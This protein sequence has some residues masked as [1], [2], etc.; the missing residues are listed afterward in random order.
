ML[1]ASQQALVQLMLTPGLGQGLVRRAVERFGEAEAALQAG[2]A[3]W[4]EIRG[5]SAGKAAEIVDHLQ[6]DAH[7]EKLDAELHAIETWQVRLLHEA[8]AGYPALLK[9]IPDPPLLL[10][11]RGRMQPEDAV[12]LGMVGS[13]RCSHYGREQAGRFASQAASAGLTV[14]SG[15]AYGIDSAAHLAAVQSQGRTLAV[16]GSG[17]AKPYPSDNGE[18][19]DRIVAND[20]GA[21]LSE[22]PMNTPPIRENFPRRNRIIS[23][24]S[25]GVLVVEAAL[26]SGALITA[27]LCV[28]E[29]GRELLAIPGRVDAPTSAGCHKIIQDG[30]AKLVTNIADVLDAL[31]DAG[32]ILKSN[33]TVRRPGDEPDRASSN[34]DAS[35]Q[36][37]PSLFEASL[38]EAQ[39]KIVKAL[40]EPCSLEELSRQTQLPAAT[41]QAELTMLEIRGAVQRQSGVFVRRQ[42]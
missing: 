24:L 5:I 21:L 33:V 1:S 27:R 23:G 10:W 25:L 16:I 18:L 13:R 36:S 14:V 35:P 17:L 20:Q 6:S 37:E 29:H 28:E 11:M 39:G 8:D 22:L 31:G 7:R 42:K 26:R 15:G 30:W 4:R 2:V 34:D 32:Q 41:L 38:N 19:F 40:A 12:A 3:G 9:M